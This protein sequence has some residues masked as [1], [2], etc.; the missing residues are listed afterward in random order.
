MAFGRRGF[1]LCLDLIV[2]EPSFTSSIRGPDKGTHSMCE[3]EI[4]PAEVSGCD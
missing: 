4:D 2:L 1:V 3:T